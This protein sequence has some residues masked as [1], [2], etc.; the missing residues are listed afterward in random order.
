ME[1]RAGIAAFLTQV[2]ACCDEAREPVPRRV[3]AAFSAVAVPR[4][5]LPRRDAWTESDVAIFGETLLDARRRVTTGRGGA[6]GPRDLCFVVGTID[7]PNRSWKRPRDTSVKKRMANSL[8]S[9]R[10]RWTATTARR[11]RSC[12][13]QRPKYIDGEFG[14]FW[15]KESVS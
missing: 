10:G 11:G 6:G 5:V 15:V 2:A 4:G 8:L 3:C 13:K 7:R 14:R 9:S 1:R 12:A